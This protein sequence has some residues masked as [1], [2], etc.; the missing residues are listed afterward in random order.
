LG[1]DKAFLQQQWVV[2]WIEV[3]ASLVFESLHIVS[4]VPSLFSSTPSLSFQI[5]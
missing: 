5:G 1:F 3:E 2:G 4:L